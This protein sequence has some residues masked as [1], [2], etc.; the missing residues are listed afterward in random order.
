M[1]RNKKEK[2]ECI[3]RINGW[4]NSISNSLGVSPFYWELQEIFMDDHSQVTI[5]V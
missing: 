3:K 2:F 4:E 1:R 5:V